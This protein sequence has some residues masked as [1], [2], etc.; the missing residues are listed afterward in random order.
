VHYNEETYNRHQ[1]YHLTTKVQI[2]NID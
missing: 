1:I 2:M